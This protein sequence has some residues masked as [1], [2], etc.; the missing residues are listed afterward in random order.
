MENLG[1]PFVYARRNVRDLRMLLVDDVL[2][3]GST[4]SD[5]PRFTPIWGPLGSRGD[6]CPG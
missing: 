1:A 5:V 3:T 2:T 4:L 6:R